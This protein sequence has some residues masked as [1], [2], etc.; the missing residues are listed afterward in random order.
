MKQLR[1]LNNNVINCELLSQRSHLVNPGIE[2][3]YIS[4]NGRFYLTTQDYLGERIEDDGFTEEEA[5]EILKSSMLDPYTT[6]KFD[7]IRNALN[8]E[9]FQSLLSYVETAKAYLTNEYRETSNPGYIA[10]FNTLNEFAEN[11]VVETHLSYK[12][13]K[14]MTNE[15]AMLKIGELGCYARA[16]GWDNDYTQAVNMGIKALEREPKY[17]SLIMAA[18]YEASSHN[19]L[20]SIGDKEA[21]SLYHKLKY[22]DYCNECDIK[23][24]DLTEDDLEDLALRE[25]EENEYDEE[26]FEQ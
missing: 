14:N 15:E 2:N 24:E 12:P 4:D 21:M 20:G 3:F 13:D 5:V 17:K 25:L 18:L 11:Y 1:N 22:E 19:L 23:Y 9:N 16:N 10:K 8:E 6:L 26:D 7:N